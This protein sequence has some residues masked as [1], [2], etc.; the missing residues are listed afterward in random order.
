MNFEIKPVETIVVGFTGVALSPMGQVT[1]PISMGDYPAIATGSVDFLVMDIPSAYNIVL[2]RPS[3]N[4]FQVVV[5]TY[6][7]KIKFPVNERVGEVKGEQLGSSR[8]YVEALRCRPRIHQ[9]DV[10]MAN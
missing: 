1:L 8:S 9:V 3:L 7:M 2:G 5:S 4:M 10:R 6:H